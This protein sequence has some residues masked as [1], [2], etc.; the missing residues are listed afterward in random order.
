MVAD[1]SGPRTPSISLATELEFIQFLAL[2]CMSRKRLLEEAESLPVGSCEVDVNLC[3]TAVLA[4]ACHDLGILGEEHIGSQLYRR[5]CMQVLG[6]PDTAAEEDE[7]D[8][9]RAYCETMQIQFGMGAANL[10][11]GAGRAGISVEIKSN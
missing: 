9:L 4:Q 2:S 6:L 7:F 11:R 8:A 10:L 1:S 5:L 3:P